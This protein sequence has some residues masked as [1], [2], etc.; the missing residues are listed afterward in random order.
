MTSASLH[1]LSRSEDATLRFGKAL[2]SALAPPIWIGLRGDLGAGKT[3]LVQG[4][5]EGLGYQ[6]RVRSPSFVLENRYLASILIQHQD[7]YRLEE[8][9]E[10]LLAGWEENRDGV[11]VVEWADRLP[12]RFSKE[13]FCVN[14]E[15]PGWGRSEEGRRTLSFRSVGG[16]EG[17]GR[18]SRFIGGLRS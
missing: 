17:A 11:I 4:I 14:I 9:D 6:G 16:D 7:L 10:E 8:P 12:I 5:A 18:L 2:G 1:W 3:R 15:Y 13:T